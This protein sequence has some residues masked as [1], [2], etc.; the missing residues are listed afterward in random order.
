MSCSATGQQSAFLERLARNKVLCNTNRSVSQIIWQ[1]TNCY[2]FKVLLWI[3]LL[4]KN[5]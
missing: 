3:V 4:T 2:N 5:Y 1:N